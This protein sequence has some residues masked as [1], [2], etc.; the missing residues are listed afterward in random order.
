MIKAIVI[1]GFILSI[2]IF[3]DCGEIDCPGFPPSFLKW[4][5]YNTL[6]TLKFWDGHNN[7]TFSVVQKSLTGPHSFKKNCKC[8]CEADMSFKATDESSQQIIGSFSALT[9]N[10]PREY[11]LG[12]QLSILSNEFFFGI[13]ANQDSF[14]YERQLYP[15]SDT[16]IS[17]INHKMVVLTVDL[18]SSNELLN[19]VFKIGK[20]FYVEGI[21]LI[22]F[23]ELDSLKKWELVEH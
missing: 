2:F 8:E 12:C 13:T 3:N 22:K 23:Q 16:L 14:Y 5:P 1:T 10:D 20:I 7:L 4:A 11:Y 6:D 15:M 19:P 21:G 18:S 9:N 17:G